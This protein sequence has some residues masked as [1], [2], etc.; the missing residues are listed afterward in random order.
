MKLPVK[1]IRAHQGFRASM[2]QLDIWDAH[3][4]ESCVHL[5]LLNFY[6]INHLTV[7]L[8]FTLNALMKGL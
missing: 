5:A 4:A 7:F 2:R 1:I 6:S 8:D 3:E